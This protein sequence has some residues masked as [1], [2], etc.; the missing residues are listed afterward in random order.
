MTKSINLHGQNFSYSTYA[1]S[2]NNLSATFYWAEK[3]IDLFIQF[4][5]SFEYDSLWKMRKNESIHIEIS[6]HRIRKKSH[7]INLSWEIFYHI[8]DISFLLSVR[9]AMILKKNVLLTCFSFTYK[10]SLFSV[11]ATVET[12][13]WSEKLLH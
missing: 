5:T 8:G 12:V 13:N 7:N 6:I 11:L 9:I 2:L 3:N 4:T 10:Q 1:Y